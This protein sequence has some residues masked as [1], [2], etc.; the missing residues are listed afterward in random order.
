MPHIEIQR[1]KETKILIIKQ[2]KANI[3]SVNAHNI[4]TKHLI[5]KDQVHPTSKPTIQTKHTCPN[6]IKNC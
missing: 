3:Q 1:L 6:N 4:L 5:I 2:L